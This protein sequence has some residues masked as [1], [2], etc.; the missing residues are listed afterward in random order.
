MS[1]L[2]NFIKK[3]VAWVI[4]L[5]LVAA[6]SIL[7]PQFR[8]WS[9]FITI[10]KQ[11]SVSGT[12]AMGVAF[13]LIAGQIDLSTGSQIALSGMV[14]SLLCV[15]AGL[16]FMV[17][18][19]IAMVVNILVI[20]LINGLA[21][22][23]THMPAM[24]ATL[25]TMNI[26]AGLA[27]WSNDGKTVYGLPDAA[28]IIGQGKIGQIPVS[29]I[30]MVGAL[31]IGAFILNKTVFGR[32]CFA[33]GSN[34]EAARLSGINVKLMIIAV[35]LICSAF[36]SLAGV[37]LMSRV[38]SGVANAGSTLFLDV[39]IAC[40][41]GGISSAG[42]EGRVFGLLGGILTMGVLANGMGVM[43]LR[44]YI[45]NLCKGA[46]LIIAVGSDAYRRFVLSERRTHVI[47]SSNTSNE[48]KTMQ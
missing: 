26:G 2:S 40:V 27:F 9:N 32:K 42:G 44:D 12:L 10:L 20:G 45:Q 33:V 31:L 4:L 17:S 24:I 22:S 38:N 36:A 19:L 3:N 48:K 16:P 23:M 28:K 30:V 7:S 11:I 39:V 15:K 8:Q 47:R 1:K 29:F 13:V 46:I 18:L 6:F 41:I 34:P 35:Y 25:G 21:V 14:C 5:V 37:M 43:G